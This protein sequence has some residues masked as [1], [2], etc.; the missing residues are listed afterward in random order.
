MTKRRFTAMNKKTIKTMKRLSF[1]LLFFVAVAGFACLQAKNA[2]VEIPFEQ[3]PMKA[4]TLVNDCYK[5]LTVKKV[6]QKTTDGLT[7]YEVRMSDK[8]IIEFD[9]VGAWNCIK[10]KKSDIPNSVY[11]R[12][13]KKTIDNDFVGKRGKYAEN[14]GLNYTIQFKDGSSAKFNAIGDVIEVVEK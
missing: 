14:D 4:Q 12:K 8:T 7:V 5:G 3:L 2:G 11:P 10:S 1:V 9:M 6:M 13:L